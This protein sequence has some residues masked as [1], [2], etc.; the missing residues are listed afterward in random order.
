MSGTREGG[1]KA[2]NTNIK[3]YG[4][5]FY[6]IAGSKGGQVGHTG[7]FAADPER[8]RWAGRKGGLKSRRNGVKNGQGKDK[9]LIFDGGANGALVFKKA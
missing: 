1:L 3:L 7:G 8:A 2:R 5:D 9:E 4:K 6:K